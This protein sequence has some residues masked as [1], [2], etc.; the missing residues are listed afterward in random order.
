MAVVT[1]KT[2]FS[3]SSPVFTGSC[4]DFFSFTSS[5][6]EELE[7]PQ[8]EDVV[9]ANLL[10]PAFEEFQKKTSFNLTF[11]RHRLC[12][13]VSALPVIR[14]TLGKLF[15]V[16]FFANPF[17]LF[18]NPPAKPPPPTAPKPPPPPEPKPELFIAFANGFVL[19][20]TILFYFLVL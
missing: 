13:I 6:D 18:P 15:P 10:K 17:S 5:W 3:S 14:K 7:F 9:P 19:F 12:R 1:S 2:F 16:S 20:E 11:I 8:D 4:L